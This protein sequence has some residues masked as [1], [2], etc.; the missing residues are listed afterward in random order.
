MT[1]NAVGDL[2]FVSANNKLYLRQSSGWYTV[3]TIAMLHQLLVQQGMLVILLLLMVYGAVT[4]T[5]AEGEATTY[6]HTVSSGSLTNGGGATA[7]VVQGTV[8]M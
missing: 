2:V 8:I 1:G 5:D 7:T 4:A 3:A 6:A